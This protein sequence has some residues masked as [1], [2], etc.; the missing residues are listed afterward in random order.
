MIPENSTFRVI[1]ASWRIGRGKQPVNLIGG[2]IR[3]PDAPSHGLR[4][5]GA[6]NGQD[7]AVRPCAMTLALR[8]A[9]QDDYDVMHD[10][11]IVGRIYR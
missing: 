1:L 3:V 7:A 5:R 10:G 9:A 6:G 11:E 2:T 8:R 4:A